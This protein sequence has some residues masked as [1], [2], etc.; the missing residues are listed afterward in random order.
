MPRFTTVLLALFVSVFVGC[1][2]A[3]PI[4]P[5]PATA[6]TK[7]IRATGRGTVRPDAGYTVSQ[8]RLLAQRASK[9]DAYRALTESIYGLKLFGT[10]SVSDMVTTNDTF[11]SYV[12]GYIRGAREVSSVAI[13]NDFTYETVL[14]VELDPDFFAY[15]QSL[16]G[17]S[18]TPCGPYDIGCR[19][20]DR[21]YYI[22]R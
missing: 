22:S 14:E 16:A 20:Q 9:M 10:T 4:K 12:A 7:T 6:T 11:K 18:F 17:P 21:Y 15:C 3:P 13:D 19:F 2:S 1:Q 5:Q 8:M